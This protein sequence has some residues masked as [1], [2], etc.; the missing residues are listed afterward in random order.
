[1]ETNA[2]A[3]SG[4]TILIVDDDP[5]IRDSLARVLQSED[6]EVRLAENGRVGARQVL[7][8]LPD[9]IL[10]DL[11]M[12]DTNGWQAFEVIAR[13]VPQVPVIVITARPDQARRAAE[14][15]IDMLL[16]KP[17]DIPVLLETIRELLAA[18]GRS[19]FARTLRAWHVLNAEYGMRD[20]E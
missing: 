7:D 9:L 4:T 20:A 2:N 16:E 11:N 14:V 19:R 1:M 17:L 3:R 12:P 10:L 15:G 5:T 18:P 8:C 13:L 6:F